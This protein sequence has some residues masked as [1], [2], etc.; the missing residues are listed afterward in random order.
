MKI[1]KD[2][3]CSDEEIKIFDKISLTWVT[4]KIYITRTVTLYLS[5]KFWM[6]KLLTKYI[7][8]LDNSIK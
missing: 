7:E 2:D 3:V 8:S 4:Y 5:V 6:L 1:L